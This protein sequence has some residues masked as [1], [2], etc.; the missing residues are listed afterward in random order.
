MRRVQAYNVTAMNELESVK[1]SLEQIAKSNAEAAAWRAKSE[2]SRAESDAWRAKLDKWRA[3]SEAS[4]AESDAWRAE[5][6]AWRA[7]ADKRHAEFK[8]ADKKLQKELAELTR[9][10]RDMRKEMGGI[11]NTQGSATEEFFL[12]ALDKD[13]RLGKLKF[14]HVR[15]NVR[16]CDNGQEA[17]FD[18]LMISDK[19]VAVIEVKHK[20]RCDDVERMREW[21]LPGFRRFLPEYGD[22]TLAPAMACIIARREVLALAHK[23]GYAILRPGGQQVRA[24]VSHL[25]CLPKG[26]APAR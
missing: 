7:V 4:R 25:R 1:R 6:D 26:R 14:K 10:T 22:R 23:Y 21:T 2:A 18:I 3:R 9:A 17:E 20:L 24:D 16:A 5:S 11:S 15:P 8:A 13:R 19:V 12:Q